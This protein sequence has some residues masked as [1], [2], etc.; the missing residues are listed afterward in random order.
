[1]T[2]PPTNLDIPK[3]KALIALEYI[4]LFLCL[5]VIALRTTFTEGPV[6]Q[7]T[8]VPMNLGNNIYSLSVSAC[9]FGSFFLWL[10]WNVFSRRFFYRPTGLE[11][12]LCLFCIAAVVS[13]FAA[14]DKRLAINTIIVFISP[15]LCAILLIQILDCRVKVNLVLAVIA[16]L[17]V[18]S[19]YQCKEQL[20]YLNEQQINLYQEDPNLLLENHEIAPDTLKQWMFEHRLYSKTVQGFFTTS[21]SAG[22]FALLASF[23]A[24]ILLIERLKNIKSDPLGIVWL[25]TCGLAVAAVI[26]GLFI[27]KSKGAIMA[28]LFAGAMFAAYLCFRNRLKDYKK[29]ILIMCILLAIAGGLVI[30]WYGLA[31]DRLPGGNSMLVRWQYWHESAKMYADH[32]VRGVGPGNFAHFY[33]HYKPASALESVA[34]PHNFPLSILTQYGP[35]GL[36]G[37]LAMIF[38]PLWTVLFPRSAG[39]LKKIHGHE[40]S[41]KKLAIALAIIISAVLLYIRPMVSPLPPTSSPQERIA[42]IIILYIMPVIVF[43]TGFLLVAAGQKPTKKS[44]ANIAVAALFC[45]VSGVILHNLIDFAI[46]EP[47]VYTTFWAIMA[48]LIATDSFAKPKREIALTHAPVIKIL[49]I[50][51]AFVICWAFVN[52]ALVP[53]AASTAKIDEANRFISTGLFDRAHRY[54][55]DAAALD[56]FSPVAS[57][58]NARLYLYRSRQEQQNSRELLNRAE[59]YLNT[60]IERNN[61]DFKNYERLAEVYVTLSEISSGPETTDFLNKAFVAGSE[62]IERYPGCGRLHFD[63]A[64][65]AEKLGQTAVAIEHYK[66]TIDIE[67]QYRDQ[68][69]QMYPEKKEIVSRL[70]EKKY[71]LAIDR[72]EELS[73]TP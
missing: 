3:S 52:Y 68:F 59:Q 37:F 27:T 4:L 13:G 29:A 51:V 32:P 18:V 63:L 5:C 44:Q 45:A 21:N 65:I 7:S 16:A 64:Q 54:L 1:M 33:T 62:A 61:A 23:A 9:L 6:M 22:S 69:R 15:L 28:S 35:I 56:K 55:D 38:I 8:T 67:N 53:V 48:C 43:I 24:I 58:L 11:I 34:D 73:F 71:Q 57:S 70:G 26:F 14:A 30:V 41:F 12:G 25:I 66:N 36:I 2:K 47:G 17:G 10:L 40:P 39:S 50:V 72:L 46:F 49:T 20:F 19:A 60:A 31:N 42:G